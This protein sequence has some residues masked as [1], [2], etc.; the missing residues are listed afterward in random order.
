[1]E[2]SQT[3][4]GWVWIDAQKDQMRFD[5]FGRLVAIA[6]AVKD[7]EETGNEMRFR[8]DGLHRLTQATSGT[9]P[10]AATSARTYD[11]HSRMTSETT[12]GK[13]VSFQLDDAGNV[14]G[15]THPSGATVSR[16]VDALDRL[17]SI[18]GVATYAY[19][20]PDLVTGKVVGAL[21]ETVGYDGARRPTSRTASAA[22]GG[23]VYDEAM[24]WSPR[25]LL[26]G[27]SRRALNETAFQMGHDGA[28]RLLLHRKHVGQLTADAGAV[29]D[30]ITELAYDPA[31]NLVEIRTEGRTHGSESGQEEVR[32][33]QP[34]PVVAQNR[35]TSI[36]GLP[37]T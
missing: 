29:S 17:E 10:G 9:G 25:S 27:Q 34:I 18:A 15:I 35:P 32:E 24:A 11:S 2:L 30:G 8:Y 5:R 22:G 23:V 6:D 21:S 13:T 36:D 28:G 33:I 4:A 3:S 31:Q 16:T 14:T 26:S 7:S 37:H 19:R 12:A 1:V 20:G